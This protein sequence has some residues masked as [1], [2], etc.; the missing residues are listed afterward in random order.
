[1]RCVEHK[2]NRIANLDNG[3]II[4]ITYDD[5][6][7]D[8]LE[9]VAGDIT[10]E[11][12]YPVTIH[13]SRIDLSPFYDSTRRQYDGNKLLKEIDALSLPR[14]HK[15]MGLFR[16]D[17]FIPILTYIFG[18]AIY[19]GE[20][21][22]AS[23]YRLRNEQ[24]GMKSDDVLLYERFRKVIIHELGHTFGLIHCH[25]PNCVMR[26]STYVEDIDQ[27]RKHLCKHCKE[28]MLISHKGTG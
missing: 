27:K 7:K 26:S 6:E 5:F 15:K 22:I 17:L 24:Y 3:Q 12:S 20:T 25:I 18:Q 9:E 4:L 19:K 28:A 21:G 14:S 13:E 10:R 11:Y 16:V 23:L 8:F 1:L 2:Q